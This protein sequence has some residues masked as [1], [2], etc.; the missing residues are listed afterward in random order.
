MKSLITMAISLIVSMNVFSQSDTLYIKGGQTLPCQITKETESQYRL[1]VPGANGQMVNSYLLK[2]LVD[3]V[4][5]DTSKASGKK[6]KKVKEEELV[7]SEP[8]TE[9][10][11]NQQPKEKAWRLTGA[12]GISLS[13][14]MDFNNPYSADK[15]SLSLNTSLDLMATYGKANNKLKMSHE[16][17]YIFGVQK[18]GLSSGYP[19]QRAQDAVNTLHD[20]SVGLGKKN[21]WNINVIAKA[22]SSF[23]TIYDGDY[24]KDIN[25]LGRIQ[26]FASPY[27]VGMAPGFKYQPNDYLRISLSPYSFELTGVKNNEISSKGIYIT[28]LNSSGNYKK[29]VYKRM[30]AEMNIWFDRSVKQWLEMQ[31]RLSVS[32]DYIEKI[33]KNGFLDALFITRVKIFKDIYLTHRAALDNNLSG[34]FWKPHFNQNIKVTYTKSF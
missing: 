23:F 2:S 24:F 32:S 12:F 30:G 33:G 5:R 1:K 3:S 11:E 19:I 17:H 26:A 25:S 7:V 14:I 21:K 16:L 4:Y 27:K 22:G 6:Q 15:K 13:N 31:Y 10:T 29:S 18:E 8:N 28:E 34:N 9:A 20:V